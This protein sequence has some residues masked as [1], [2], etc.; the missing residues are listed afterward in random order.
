MKRMTARSRRRSIS[1]A[2]PS[3]TRPSHR[4]R[5]PPSPTK[6]SVHISERAG[7]R[8]RPACFLGMMEAGGGRWP[9]Y[10][11]ARPRPEL[12]VYRDKLRPHDS[13]DDHHL[14]PPGPAIRILVGYGANWRE[15]WRM[16]ADDL[17]AP[18]G[19]ETKRG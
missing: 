12:F 4:I 9:R 16:A 17:S 15:D 6:R 8:G 18:L 2:A 1:C 3:R 5:R 19:Q 11:T 13:P 7:R 10:G 14:P